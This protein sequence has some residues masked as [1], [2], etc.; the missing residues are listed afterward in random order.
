MRSRA[1][2]RNRLVSLRHLESLNQKQENNLQ[3]DIDLE[4]GI[5]FVEAI[6][7][8]VGSCAVLI[9]VVGKGWVNRCP[10]AN[11]ARIAVLI[12]TSAADLQPFI[13]SL[14]LGKRGTRTWQSNTN[15]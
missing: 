13:R 10:L 8:S 4:A 12:V 1:R 15:V 2:R 3:L 14:N 9:A 7:Q 5:D 11:I 6:G